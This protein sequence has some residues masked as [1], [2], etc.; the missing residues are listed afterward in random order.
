MSKQK[1]YEVI[2]ENKLGYLKVPENVLI[3]IEL[4]KRYQPEDIVIIT[5]GSQGEPMSALS[6]MAY[7]DHRKVEIT[8]DDLIII[9]ATPIP[10]N[11][12]AVSEVIKS[13]CKEHGIDIPFIYMEPGRSIVADAGMTLYTVGT[14]KKIPGYKNYASIDGGMTDNPR[15]ALYESKYSVFLANRMEEEK[16]FTCDVVGRCC[17]SGDIIQPDVAMP[18]PDRGDIVAVLTTGAYNYSMASNYNRIP[19]PPIITVCDGK[20]KVAVKR[21]SFEDLVRNDI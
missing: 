15:Y 6:R 14:V 7:S 19:R 21:E 9:S 13:K 12:K 10:G 4:I 11:E 3:D 18:E 8:K 2:R 5:T 1:N 20:A 17:E 16:T